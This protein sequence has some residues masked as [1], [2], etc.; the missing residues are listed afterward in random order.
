MARWIEDG[1]TPE[2]EPGRRV[3]QMGWSATDLEGWGR[4]R[5][6][7]GRRQS[8]GRRWLAEMD[9]D[10]EGNARCSFSRCWRMVGTGEGGWGG[11]GGGNSGGDG[12]R[13]NPD[14]LDQHHH[15]ALRRDVHVQQ[16]LQAVEGTH[17]RGSDRG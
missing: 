1:E 8:K 11:A 14:L 4:Q 16:R 15:A 9:W 7:V 5:K 6:R 12:H 17:G 2:Q 10:G 13:G 3:E